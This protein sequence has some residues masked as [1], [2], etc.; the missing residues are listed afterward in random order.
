MP[1]SY[2]LMRSI[3]RL[4]PLGL[5]L[6]LVS[7]QGTKPEQD[8]INYAT[9][10]AAFKNP[11][12]SARPK[13]YWWWLNGNVDTVR[14]KEELRAIKQ[15]G[16][17]GVDI[18]EIGVS[19]ANNPKDM[20][21]A[22]PA[23]MGVESLKAIE[24]A[25][26]E[27]TRLNLEVGLN[28]A[29]SWNAGGSWITPQYAAKSIYVSKTVIDGGSQQTIKLPFPQISRLDER[30]K[31][32]V[33]VYGA[34]GRPVYHEEIA[35]VAVPVHDKTTTLDT[36][37]I[38]SLSPL[39]DVN[40]EMLTWTIP[41]GKWEVY[42]YICANSGEQLKL[43]SA[44]SKGP[45]IDHFDSLATRAH[46]QYFIDKLKPRLG[47]FSKTTL[48]TLYLASYEA[49]GFVWTPSL[50][51]QFKKIHGYSIDKFLPALFDKALLSPNLATDFEQDFNRTLSD[52]MIQNHYRKASEICHEQGLQ[53]ASEAGGP[54]PPLHNVPVETLKALGALDVPRGE[55]WSRYQYLAPD[56]VDIMW[57]VKEIAAA[58]HIYKRRIVEEESFTSFHHWQE[59][60]F[61][62][63]PIAD[64]AFC[65]GMNRVVVHGF[66]HNPSGTGFPGIVYNAGTHFNDKQ[67]WWPKIK[68]FTDYLGR[69]SYVLQNTDYVAD[70]VYYY[71]DQVP[72][73]VAPK[74]TRFTVGSGFDYE[75]INTDILLHD[76]T[77]KDGQLALSNGA[78]FK[79]LAFDKT[80]KVPPS[81]LTKLRQLARQGAQ[82]SG[83]SF[84][85]LAPL[86]LLQQQAVKPDFSVSDVASS[87]LDYVHYHQ[88]DTDFYLVRNTTDGWVS[89]RC[90]FRQTGKTPELWDAVTGAVTP[91]SIYSQDGQQIRLPLTLPPYG[92]TFVVFRK[93]AS[94]PHFTDMRT[95]TKRLPLFAYT[96]NGVRL[97]TSG[98]VELVGKTK[99]SEKVRTDITVQP[100]TGSWQLRFPANW[101]APETITLPK[102]LSWTDSDQP[103][104]KYFSGTG[105]YEKN[106]P[107]TTPVSLSRNERIYLDLGQLSEIADVWFN[108]K[109]LGI[110]WAEPYR[111]DITDVVQKGAN[112]LKIEVANTWSN[113]L[114][115]DAIR[116]EKFTSTNIAIGYKGAPWKQVPL[117]PSGL[118]GPVTIQTVKTS[119]ST[120]LNHPTNLRP[121]P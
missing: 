117:I 52:L 69:V 92:A 99:S 23:F 5:L 103:G 12:V 31:P 42:R 11:P 13:V 3:F 51:A 44:N 26:R 75:I 118:L 48:K 15:A 21:K 111:F 55:F 24:L 116:G 109:H 56:S 94:Q 10:K 57:L 30:G 67:T 113:R 62:L 7:F 1:C 25:I 6:S 79:V 54:G 90:S 8:E 18:F 77:V 33:I 112:Q 35:V 60:P 82:I 34:D 85:E 37:Q 9:L 78:R 89:N 95:D 104:V 39:F 32:R 27:A 97:L 66:S 38:V 50:P 16:I 93:A 36:T 63:K 68:P 47:D 41:P 76:L 71:G 4:L 120:T 46:F 53:I 58:A 20:V 17:G 114:T 110:I 105:T 108:G 29:S 83:P 119:G 91:V 115:G 28:L 88:Q 65:E 81:V 14:I 2:I 64:R 87:A 74:N 121:I 70:V 43:P 59:G 107:F 61:D 73:F 106:V 80:A 22:G 102:L 100:V 40:K 19:P 45:I 84:F 86:S 49:T 101:G 72:N 96:T 98:T